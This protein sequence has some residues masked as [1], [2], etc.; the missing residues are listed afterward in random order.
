MFSKPTKSQKRLR[1]AITGAS[2]SGKTYSA[3]SIASHLGENVGVI[4]TER[5]SSA[6]YCDEFDFQICDLVN[7]SPEGYIAAI[8]AASEFDVLIIDSFSHAWYELLNMA[9]QRFENWAKVRP[10][11][12]SL[13]NAILDHPGHCLITMRTKSEYVVEMVENKSGRM[14]NQPRKVGTVPIQSK[15]IEYEFDIS[16]NLNADHVLTIDKTRCAALDRMEFLNPGQELADILTAWLTDGAPLPETG[17]SKA[18][19]VTAAMPEGMK[20]ALIVQ[21]IQDKWGESITT[22]RQL[23]SA[24]VDELI[25]IIQSKAA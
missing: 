22:P 24:Q 8:K 11:E 25:T 1:M 17:D 15:D 5:G 19:R 20:K 12:R 13:I 4:D 16:G 6:L 7:P 10:L 23:T 14:S 3:L 18:A 9:G 2:G 21:L